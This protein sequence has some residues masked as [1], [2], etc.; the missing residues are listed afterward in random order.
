MHADREREQHS[1]TKAKP[2][3]QH[4]SYRHHPGNS[5]RQQ[6]YRSTG[7]SGA[8]IGQIMAHLYSNSCMATTLPARP[9]WHS[10]CAWRHIVKAS[11]QARLR[12]PD[13]H[14]LLKHVN[15]S[16]S[17]V[18]QILLALNSSQRF[19]RNEARRC[20]TSGFGVI[21]HQLETFHWF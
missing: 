3:Q 17:R 4:G 20:L 1:K 10:N 16:T 15:K 8:R 14:S 13:S 2:W 12:E 19:S 18:T 6:Q 5:A 9:M 7:T 11:P 21:S